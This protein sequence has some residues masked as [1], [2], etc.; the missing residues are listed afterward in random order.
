MDLY[1]TTFGRGS[2]M[3]NDILGFF[4]ADIAHSDTLLFA[5]IILRIV[6]QYR[7]KIALAGYMR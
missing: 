5:I 1:V 6:E 4:S 2:Y 3:H 7:Q